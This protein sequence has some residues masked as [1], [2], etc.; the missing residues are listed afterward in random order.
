MSNVL[1]DL[2]G[3]VYTCSSFPERLFSP[4]KQ[5][6]T[7]RPVGGVLLPL[8]IATGENGGCWS[9]MNTTRPIS[10]PVCDPGRRLSPF[11]GWTNP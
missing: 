2:Q 9:C 10:R 11:I 8:R 3:A 1:S 7:G 6:G 5:S 4:T